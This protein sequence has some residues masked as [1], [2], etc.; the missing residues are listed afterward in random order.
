MTETPAPC[1]VC[2]KPSTELLEFNGLAREARCDD[3]SG[4]WFSAPM[5][6][7]T[8]AQVHLSYYGT[9]TVFT[10]ALPEDRP[11]VDAWLAAYVQQHGG[12]PRLPEIV[13]QVL[14]MRRKADELWDAGDKGTS[15]MLHGFA[16]AL[17]GLVE[18][19]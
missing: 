17:S 15:S 10:V 3:H 19:S 7:H 9:E 12:L 13:Q 6:G 11:F 1:T 18:Q 5:Q 16:S 8:S 2:G 4:D 14:A